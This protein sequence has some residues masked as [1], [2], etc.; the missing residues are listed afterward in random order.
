MQM[1]MMEKALKSG[2]VQQDEL[3]KLS[4][5]QVIRQLDEKTDDKNKKDETAKDE[6]QM[7]RSF[8]VRAMSPT[9]SI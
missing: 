7:R 9:K 1:Q 6:S 5:H 4:M 3:G 8:S 2:K